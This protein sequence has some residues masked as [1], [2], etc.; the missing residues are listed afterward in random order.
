MVDLHTLTTI[1]G[2]V[3]LGAMILAA[4]VSQ[5]RRPD[6]PRA[7]YSVYRART[8]REQWEAWRAIERRMI[9]RSE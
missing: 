7:R 8:R 6:D 1:A 5:L 3:S 9:S 4:V 2:G